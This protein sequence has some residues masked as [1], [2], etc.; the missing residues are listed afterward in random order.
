MR[1]LIDITGRRFGRLVVVE[2]IGG[3]RLKWLC[4]CDCGKSCLVRGN[5][6]RSGRQ[7]S[8]GCMRR[9]NMR[10]VGMSMRNRRTI[11]MTGKRCGW[12]TVIKRVPRPEYKTGNGVWWLCRCDC[13]TERVVVGTTLRN[14]T[15]Q[16]C[17]CMRADMTRSKWNGYKPDKG[18]EA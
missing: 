8:C 11:D 5:F 18:V 15:S 12:W 3:Q 13:G 1:S 17:G 16:S 14:G 2:Y 6:L 10:Q 4:I 9:E 7:Q